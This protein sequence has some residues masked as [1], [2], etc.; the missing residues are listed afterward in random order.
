MV[1]KLLCLKKM[2]NLF[3]LKLEGE[4]ERGRETEREGIE[5]CRKE[6]LRWCCQRTVLWRKRWMASLISF[7][8]HVILYSWTMCWVNGAP[9]L[10]SLFAVQRDGILTEHIESKSLN[11]RYRFP[12]V[13]L[14]WACRPHSVWINAPAPL[15]HTHLSIMDPSTSLHQIS[16]SIMQL[17]HTNQYSSCYVYRIHTS[18]NSEHFGI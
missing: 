1:E 16:G 10:F 15:M 13:H 4:R 2:C 3:Q 5:C 12:N 6:G 8:S 11:S 7:K 18:T 17:A 9:D 14:N